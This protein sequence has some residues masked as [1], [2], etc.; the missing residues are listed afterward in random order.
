MIKINLA[1]GQRPFGQ[2]WTNVDLIEQFDSEGKRYPLDIQTDAKDL[3]MFE[4]NSVD[5]IVA[6][7]LVEHIAIH[8]LAEY[9]HE[10]QRILK[11]GGILS[12]HVPNLR[13]L[14]KAW[15]EGRIDSYTHN[16]NTYGAYQGHFEDTHKWGY[17]AQELK[18]RLS[19][20]NGQVNEV[21]WSEVREYRSNNSL[22][23]GADIAQ[24]WWILSMEFVK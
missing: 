11:P 3:H 18:D 20:W 1:S 6:H 7:H 10:W 24:D 15:I 17:D 16:V 4:D 2:G 23:I 22:Y 14:D 5:I 8:D 13:E 21:A 19:Q 12:I 9:I